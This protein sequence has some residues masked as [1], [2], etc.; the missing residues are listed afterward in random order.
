MD[1]QQGRPLL[2]ANP[3]RAPANKSVSLLHST[4][5]HGRRVRHGQAGP[6]SIQANPLPTSSSKPNPQ[7]DSSGESSNAD[8]WF[9]SS[10]NNVPDVTSTLVD[11]TLVPRKNTPV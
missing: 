2:P 8:K 10:N 11:S 1:K 7:K 3:R 4:Y 6:A 5:P 9:E